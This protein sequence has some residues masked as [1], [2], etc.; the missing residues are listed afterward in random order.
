[1][2]LPEMATGDQEAPGQAAQ[3]ADETVT[4]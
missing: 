3:D 2:F 4:I 1:V